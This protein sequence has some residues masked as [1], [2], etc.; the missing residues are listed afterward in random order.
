MTN[1][2]TQIK[3]SYEDL[4]MSPEE[5][6]VDRNLDILAVKACLFTVSNKFRKDAKEEKKGLQEGEVPKT[7]FTDEE[8][9]RARK[10]ILD[11]ALG[12]DNEGVALKAAMY[13]NDEKH[14]RHDI[15]GS[16]RGL[17]FNVLNFNAMLQAADRAVASALDS[18]QKALDI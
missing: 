10:R 3:M 17:N 1:E 6:S 15:V 9:E 8:A 2:Q 4:Q 14:G 18:G 7:G 16:V 13:V 12:S 11:I 5:I